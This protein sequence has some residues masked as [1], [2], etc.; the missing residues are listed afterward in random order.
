MRREVELLLEGEAREWEIV[1]VDREPELAARYG[2]TIPVLFVNDRLF[3]KVRLP[4][5]ALRL[6][7]RRA[8]GL[9]G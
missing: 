4:R 6:R 1:D 3:A 5:L 8:A 7:L 9:S 2:E